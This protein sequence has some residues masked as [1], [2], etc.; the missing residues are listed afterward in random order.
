VNREIQKLRALNWAL[1]ALGLG[2]LSFAL[3]SIT[4]PVLMPGVHI[5]YGLCAG[6]VIA[7]AINEL[8]SL[9]RAE[10]I[11]WTPL[12]IEE[13]AGDE[14]KVALVTMK[15]GEIVVIAIPE[16]IDTTTPEGKIWVVREALPEKLKA[17]LDSIE[18]DDD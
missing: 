5:L 12:S 8:R 13:I 3:A 15:N 11:G 2:T 1:L 9:S 18:V 16:E 14:G 10:L 7:T 4:W 17:M 6:A